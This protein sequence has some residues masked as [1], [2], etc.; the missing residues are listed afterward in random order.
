MRVRVLFHDHCF[1]GAASAALF[2]AFYHT[3]VDARAHIEYWGM[4]HGPGNVFASGAF[5]SESGWEHACV[6]FRYSPDSR[7]T[8]WFDH[9]QS[10]FLS[11]DEEAH[12]YRTK[13]PKHFYDPSARSCSKFLAQACAAQFGFSLHRYAE[14]IHWADLID[15]AQFDSPKMAV[16]VKE[17]ALRLMMWVEAN[18]NQEAKR[19]FIRDLQDHSLEE[20]VQTSYVKPALDGLLRDHEQHVSWMQTKMSEQQGVVVYDTSEREVRVANKFIPYYAYPTCHYVVGLS[21]SAGRLKIS[22][23][24]NP[25]QTCQRTVNLATVC[26]SYGGGGHPVVGAISLPA[27]QQDRAKRVLQDIVHVLQQATHAERATLGK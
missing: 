6:D 18:R 20:L 25:W 8:W 9:H 11:A 14:L 5:R 10:A 21:R 17:P 4:N 13:N 16:E 15:G 27:E 2:S 7:L 24:F 12:F 23:G 26:A 3:C 19:F 22:V 1:D